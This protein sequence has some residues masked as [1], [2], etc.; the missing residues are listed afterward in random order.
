MLK[1]LI[2]A[3]DLTGALDTGVQLA[4]L[5]V[6]TRV[7]L[8]RGPGTVRNA[9]TAGTLVV[10][11]ES[12][13][14]PPARAGEIVAELVREAL[15]A[16]AEF[17]YKKTD[18]ALRGNLGAELMAAARAAGV[19]PVPFVPAW[20]ENGRTTRAGIHYINGVPLAETDLAADVLNP[21]ASSRVAEI[22]SAEEALDVRVA[23]AGE[24][25]WPQAGDVLV[26]DAQTGEQVDAVAE[27]LCRRGMLL[28]TAGCARLLQGLSS[29]LAPL[30]PRRSE[31]RI[32]P[33]G[34]VL[35]ACGSLNPASLGQVR[36]AVRQLGYQLVSP[37][38]APAAPGP[39]V[40]PAGRRLVLRSSRAESLEDV[41]RVLEGISR[42]QVEAEARRTAQAMGE[43][44]GEIMSCTDVGTLIVFGGDTLAAAV[45]RL[46]IQMLE[47]LSELA[48]GVVLC[49]TFADGKALNL[50]TKA[51]AFGGAEL[52]ETIERAWDH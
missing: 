47:P 22:L 48:P 6:D 26:F 27:L 41:G 29:G 33:L 16:G 8:Y 13:H 17:I 49:R 28:L 24:S 9:G 7:L 3:D 37:D 31:T 46:G 14:L 50:V 10:D 5:G 42:E 12:R 35:L 51:G 4:R 25:S 15:E 43:R 45:R 32:G 19:R 40:I 38:G 39:A 23:A 34:T 20:P 18:S 2:A 1:L 44:I 11:T 30:L 36:Y 52:V 21:I